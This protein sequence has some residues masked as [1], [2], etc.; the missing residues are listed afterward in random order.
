MENRTTFAVGWCH[1]LFGAIARQ[2][3]LYPHST[4][5]PSLLLHKNSVKSTLDADKYE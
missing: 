2:Y 5:L 1:L 4:N 3:T